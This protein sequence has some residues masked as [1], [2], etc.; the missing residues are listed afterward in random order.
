MKNFIKNNGHWL[1]LSI[2]CAAIIFAAGRITQSHAELCKK[3]D[4]KVEK[5]LYYEHRQ[6]DRRE[7]DL[8]LERIEAKI[9]D[10]TAFI[11]ERR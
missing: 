9:D 3:V 8:Q 4:R 10:L 1:R 11:K 7:L 2:L 5:E 6:A